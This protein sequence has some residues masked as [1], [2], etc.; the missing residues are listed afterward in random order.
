ML[1]RSG[2]TPIKVE[3][4]F[5]LDLHKSALAIRQLYETAK[6]ERWSPEKDIQWESFDATA[7]EPGARAAARRVWSRRAWIEYTGLAE[8]P[9]L[10]IRFCLERDR[11]ADPKYFLTVRNTEEAWH[12][13]CFHRYAEACGGYIERPDNAQWEPLFNQSLY[14]DALDAEL[15]ID[16]YVFTH[17]AFV[18]GLECEL[19]RAWRDN[20]RD[21]VARAILDRCLVDRQ[22]HAEFGWLYAQRRAAM[23]DDV[24][25]A[26]VVSALVGHIE[27]VEFAGYSCV[28][29]A[30]VLDAT[31]EIADLAVVAQAG[32]GGISA[33][34]EVELFADH[35]A[36]SRVRLADLGVML[37]LMHHAR[38][39][40]V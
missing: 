16:G 38:L 12:L 21:P 34:A 4:R 30:T 39:G 5:P 27:H 15:G 14:R 35:L 11:E 23:L 8:T 28:G 36:E 29:L 13:E 3:R 22:R 6:V 9:A 1:G 19:T 24:Q 20:A 33:D 26:E 17:C 25:R 32:L 2:P 37:P 18:D 7:H 31:A 10:V 40:A